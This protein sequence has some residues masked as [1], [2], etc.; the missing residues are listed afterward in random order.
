MGALM[1]RLGPSTRTACIPN[2]F[3]PRPPPG[4]KVRGVDFSCAR[5]EPFPPQDKRALGA[6]A[7]A[8]PVVT[9]RAGGMARVGNIHSSTSAGRWCPTFFLIFFSCDECGKCASTHVRGISGVMTLHQCPSL[10]QG[11]RTRSRTPIKGH[12]LTK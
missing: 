2:K 3:T 7:L 12:K 8:C 1:G 4:K 9:G 5:R 10:P 6:L 11:H